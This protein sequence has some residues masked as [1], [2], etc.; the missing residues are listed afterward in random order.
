MRAWVGL[1]I[2][3]VAIV[4]T[5]CA[6]YP[7][8]QEPSTAVSTTAGATLATLATVPVK[9]RAAMTGYSSQEAFWGMWATPDGVDT[10][11]DTRNYVLDRDLTSVT[12]KAGSNCL[13]QTGTLTDPY[14]GQ[15][16]DFVRAG[17]AGHDGG[18]Q[19]DHVVA[20]GNAWATG[21][22]AW[23]PAQRNAFANDPLDLLAVSSTAN[24][25]K[26]DGDA[27]TWLPANKSFRCQ[28]VTI[29]VQVKATY[30]LWMTQA[31][32]DAI[33]HILEGC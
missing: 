16:I 6:G 1:V 23:T 25:Q 22:F 32:H 18:V 30:G 7:P 15:V 21:G 31:E 24:Q 28:Y 33:E 4:A 2:A 8:T 11:C 29:Q 26:G 17:G 9:G 12:K 20:R 13:I 14:T 27:A 10:N 19:I 3:A 5:G